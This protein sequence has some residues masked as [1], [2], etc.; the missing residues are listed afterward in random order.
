MKEC[1]DLEVLVMQLKS[2][3]YDGTSIMQ[4]CIA[5]ERLIKL[6]DGADIAPKWISV[7][8]ELPIEKFDGAFSQIGVIVTDGDNVCEMSFYVGTDPT[9][10]RAWSKYGDIEPALITHWQR[11]PELPA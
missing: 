6:K 8:D 2:G 10:W 7:D 1:T 5:I 4:A 3:E 9:S 11:K